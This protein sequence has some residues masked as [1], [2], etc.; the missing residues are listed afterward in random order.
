[1]EVTPSTFRMSK[2]PDMAKKN[3]GGKK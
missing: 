2:N 1:L 3:K